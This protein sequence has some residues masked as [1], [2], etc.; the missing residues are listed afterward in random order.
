MTW[1]GVTLHENPSLRLQV[2]ALTLRNASPVAARI[3]SR[4]RLRDCGRGWFSSMPHVQRKDACVGSPIPLVRWCLLPPSLLGSGWLVEHYLWC[5]GC[6]VHNHIQQ[7]RS[8][9]KASANEPDAREFSVSTHPPW[10]P[11][12]IAV[13]QI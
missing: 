6:S 8:R 2:S 1:T 12:R 10:L 7:G 9:H 11:D 13:M 4:P 3:G 5:D